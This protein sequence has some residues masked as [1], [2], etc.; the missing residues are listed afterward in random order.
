MSLG[1][2][3]A[4]TRLA[5]FAHRHAKGALAAV[6][7]HIGYKLRTRALATLGDLKLHKVRLGQDVR[8]VVAIVGDDRK[9][10]GGASIVSVTEI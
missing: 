3:S 2:V 6:D 4:I 9:R 5:R 7:V 10:A 8:V 1:S